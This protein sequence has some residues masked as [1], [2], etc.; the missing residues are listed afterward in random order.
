MLNELENLLNPTAGE[1]I[2]LQIC[3]AEKATMTSLYLKIKDVEIVNA[4]IRRIYAILLH[5]LTKPLNYLILSI[6]TKCENALWFALIDFIVFMSV[7]MLKIRH[8]SDWEI[9]VRQNDL[10]TYR[11]DLAC[12][13]SCRRGL[14]R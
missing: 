4:N 5:G 1:N 14:S 2:F 7:F 8:A 9:G 10:V 3:A 13:P 11:I 6:V 12:K